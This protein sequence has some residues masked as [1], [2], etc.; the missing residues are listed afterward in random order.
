MGGNLATML[1]APQKL[2]GPGYATRNI[3]V[4]HVAAATLKTLCKQL[5]TSILDDRYG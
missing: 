2:E 3:L 4:N 5:L 1:D